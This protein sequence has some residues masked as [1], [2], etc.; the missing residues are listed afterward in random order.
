M[1]QISMILSMYDEDCNASYKF[2][3]HAKSENF[4]S[5]LQRNCYKPVRRQETVT[6]EGVHVKSF[7]VT[8]GRMVSWIAS[9]N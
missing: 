7:W 3:T 2:S 9:R 4:L 6:N 5:P 8:K 1:I